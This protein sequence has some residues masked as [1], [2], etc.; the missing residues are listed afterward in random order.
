MP[1]DL[2]LFGGTTGAGLA[3]RVA[4][5][6]GQPL[7]RCMVERFPDGELNVR[8]EEPVRG[9]E[10]FVVQPTCPPVNDSLVELLCFAD[11]C[12][13]SSALSVTAVVPYFGYARSDKRRG[14]P[15]PIAAS[16]V[17]AMMQAVGIGHLITVDL[18]AAQIEGFFQIPVDDLTAVPTLGRALAGLLPEG[19]MVVSPDE[20]RFRTASE[21]G[22]LLGAPVATLHKQR[23]D[24]VSTS[25]AQVVG[26]VAVLGYLTYM[27]VWELERFERRLLSDPYTEEDEATIA[28]LGI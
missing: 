7:G 22:R 21:Y 6:L 12:R 11:A 19:T 9:R 25:V 28:R 2:T 10:V 18:H 16:M 20:G 15:T 13:R 1:N 5:L 4:Q 27:E 17:A 3:A 24:G 8:L 14:R 23:Q 26:D